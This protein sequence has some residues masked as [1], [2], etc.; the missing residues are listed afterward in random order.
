MKRYAAI[1]L[2]LVIGRFAS[3]A[4]DSEI[5]QTLCKVA[6]MGQRAAAELSTVCTNQAAA[7]EIRAA[8]KAALQEYDTFG[9]NSYQTLSAF[10]R[11]WTI[12]NGLCSC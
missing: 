10:I 4:D 7:E 3:A 8:A 12:T 1:V 2:I 6:F 5:F 11:G 9:T